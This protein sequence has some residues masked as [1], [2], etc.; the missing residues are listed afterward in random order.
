M[1]SKHPLLMEVMEQMEQTE[2]KSERLQI[3]VEP[4]V[5]DRIDDFRFGHRI[6]SRSEATRRL[7]I[8]GLEAETTTKGN[9]A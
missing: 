1:K 7:L 6:G 5:I 2:L 9:A 4:S 8:K 3:V